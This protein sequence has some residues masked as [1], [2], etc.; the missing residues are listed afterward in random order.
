MD[1]SAITRMDEVQSLIVATRALRKDVGVPEKESVPIHL[2][3]D[4][5][6]LANLV[7]NIEIV[8]KLAKVHTVTNSSASMS[9]SHVR[10]MSNYQL[11]LHYEKQV[12]PAAEL[13]RLTKDLAQQEKEFANNQRQLGN[14]N[15]L[16]KAPAQVVEG[17]RT[18]AAEL[19]ALLEKN[20]AAL[21]ALEGNRS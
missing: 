13:A 15:F 9:A 18:R 1:A 6:T 7:A 17:L 8:G 19:T 14:E 16:A 4:V 5:D 2:Q 21:A 20:R 12:D 10:A 3:G 11:H